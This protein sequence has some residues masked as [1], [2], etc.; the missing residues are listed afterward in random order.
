MTSLCL[1]QVTRGIHALPSYI[2]S[3][4]LLLNNPPRPQFLCFEVWMKYA[5]SR[6]WS[7]TELGEQGG[8]SL[9]KVKYKIQS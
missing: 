9:D 7:G 4:H 2:S 6:K 8:Q 5:D 1:T 3:W